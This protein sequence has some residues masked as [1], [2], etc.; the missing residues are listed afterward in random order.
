VALIMTLVTLALMGAFLAEMHENSA[1]SF[2]V[3]RNQ[4][5]RL[6]SE[7]MAKSGLNLTRLL[8]SQEPGIRQTVAPI[9]QMVLGRPPPQLPVWRLAN[10]ILSPFCD[11]E[12][13]KETAMGAGIALDTAEGLG[14]TPGTCEMVALPENSKI[15]LSSPLLR[16][17]DVARTS[18]A[19]QFFALVGGYQSPSPFD[20]IFEQADPDG[21]FTSRLDMVSDIIDW[22]DTD[23]NRTVFDPG[24][25]EVSTSGAEDDVY[26]SFSDPYKVKNAPFDSLEE[27]R[28]V[29]GVGDDFW[30]T[31]VEP[32]PDDPTSR[33]VTVYGSGS[34]NPNEAPAEVLI[35]RLCSYLEG[36]PLCTDPVEA[37]KFIQ[38][39]RT[40]RSIFP[41]P[42]FTRSADFLNFIEGKGGAQDLYPILAGLLGPENPLLF[43]PV[44]IPPEIRT[45]LDNSFVMKAEIFT[46]VSKG[47]VGRTEVQIRAVV[48]YHDRWHPPPP[49]P[50]TVPGLGVFHYYR[51]D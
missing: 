11:Y 13:G 36:Q 40:A 4:R 14:E 24:A 16:G 31:F 25:G 19:M 9:Y 33:Q 23:T 37:A 2:A 29:R 22:W 17:G 44:S 41:I 45:E 38:L 18:T 39:V 3:A 5:E 7:Y 30:A 48:N 42:F 50:G 51:M 1:T 15:N 43:A 27:L 26:T 21:N 49:N 47:F 8:I 10:E 35:A 12:Q 32:D 28:L 46:I 20:P 6:Q 34:V